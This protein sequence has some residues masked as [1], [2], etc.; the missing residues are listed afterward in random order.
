MNMNVLPMRYRINGKNKIEKIYPDHYLK[1]I[2]DTYNFIKY[3]NG[4]NF[5]K[6]FSKYCEKF[7]KIKSGINTRNLFLDNFDKKYSDFSVDDNGDIIKVYNPA[8]HKNKMIETDV[9]ETETYYNVDINNMPEIVKDMLIEIIGEKFFYNKLMSGK[10]LE[11]DFL[12]YSLF[13][14]AKFGKYVYK[15]FNTFVEIASQNF[16][17]YEF[18]HFSKSTNTQENIYYYGK[19]FIELYIYRVKKYTCK[20]IERNS[21]EHKRYI[22]ETKIE[23]NRNK[24]SRKAYSKEKSEY[25]EYIMHVRKQNDKIKN[26]EI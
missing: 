3:H 22:A 26:I 25:A 18:N 13:N 11:K 9:I 20:L 4:Q 12:N 7:P 15:H 19:K 8:R 14:F 2:G 23:N 21:K 24:K 1:I 16:S 6:T 5:N 17:N 10:I